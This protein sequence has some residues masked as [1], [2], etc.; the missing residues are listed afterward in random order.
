MLAHQIPKAYLAPVL[1]YF[2]TLFKKIKRKINKE[3]L[4]G[5]LWHIGKWCLNKHRS[6]EKAYR[7]IGIYDANV[8]ISKENNNK[9]RYIIVCNS[10]ISAHFVIITLIMRFLSSHGELERISSQ[11][12][13][14]QQQSVRCM[15]TCFVSGVPAVVIAWTSP[16]ADHIFGL[17][18]PTVTYLIVTPYQQFVASVLR[19][20]IEGANRVHCVC[21]FLSNGKDDVKIQ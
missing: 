13:R 11:P 16:T 12:L 7:S 1:N 14:A 15:F 4:K 6:L 8:E 5:F 17:L 10:L 21:F 19:T 3:S 20:L 18:S 9:K 2:C